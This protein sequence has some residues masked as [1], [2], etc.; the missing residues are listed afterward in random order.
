[1]IFL[2]CSAGTLIEGKVE[3]INIEIPSDLNID[4]VLFNPNKSNTV[5]VSGILKQDGSFRLKSNKEGYYLVHIDIPSSDYKISDSWLLNDPVQ[6]ISGHSIYLED[7]YLSTK[8][9]LNTN[10]NNIESIGELKF[11]WD[12][13]TY[14]DYYAVYINKENQD[15][16]LVLLYVTSEPNFTD[17]L[18]LKTIP[19]DKKMSSG[20]ISQNA[21][22]LRIKKQIGEGSYRIH[23]AAIKEIKGGLETIIARSETISFTIN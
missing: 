20:E 19:F 9:V 5:K 14:A 8:F 7:L 12:H 2:S 15:N 22:F 10:I 16:E 18:A 3:T 1:M 11:S 23:V 13:I 6:L 4:F 17:A 21:P